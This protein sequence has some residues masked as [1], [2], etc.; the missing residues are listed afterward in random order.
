M[1]MLSQ[2]ECEEWLK[3]NVGPTVTLENVEDGYPHRVSYSMPVDTGKKT[4]L[5][6]YVTHYSSIDVR[7]PGLFWITLHGVWPSSE[8]MAIFDGYRSSL[9]ET[10]PLDEA[11]GLVFDHTDLQALECLLALTLY[12]YWDSSLLDGAGK[13]LFK[14]GHDEWLSVCAKDEAHLARFVDTLDRLKLTRRQ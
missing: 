1:K 11:P 7:Q 5:A 14:T 13:V 4:A 6:H 3:A 8:N 10:R 9:G 2:H 12:F